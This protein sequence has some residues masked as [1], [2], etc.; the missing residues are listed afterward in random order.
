M[1]GLTL[2][3]PRA[4]QR[5]LLSPGHTL[6]DGRFRVE[7][8]L[9]SGGEGVVYRV[10]D[11]AQ[12]RSIA[13]KT[14]HFDDDASIPNLKREFRFLRDLI[15]PS[16]VQLHELV[17]S[18]EIAFF[19]MA[20]VTGESFLTAAKDEETLREL[21]I[22]LAD[23]TAFLHTTGRVHRDIK[24]SNILV[25]PNGSL[26]LLDFGIGLNLKRPSESGFRAQGTPR[27]M[28]PELLRGGSVSPACDAFS[29]GVLLYEALTGAHPSP[30]GRTDP[31]VTSAPRPSER[32]P[33]VARDLDDLVESLLDPAPATRGT[34]E[35]ILELTPP[36]SGTDFTS[37]RTTISGEIF[38]GRLHELGRLQESFERVQEGYKSIVAF[39]EAESG[40][41]KTAF[42]NRFLESQADALVFRSKCSEHE[43][44]PHKA[45]DG[46]ID[47]LV[48]YLL[49]KRHD[50]VEEL[51]PTDDAGI[52][53]QLFPEFGR[54]PSLESSIP[55]SRSKG[56]YRAL[57][58]RAYLAL[59]GVLGRVSDEASLIIAIDDL[60]WGDTDSGRLLREVFAG[61]DRPRCLLVLAYRSEERR[62]SPCLQGVLDGE[63]SLRAELT[64]TTIRLAPLLR[65][66]AYELISNVAGSNRLAPSA[67][68]SIVQEAKGSPLLLTELVTHIRSNPASAHQASIGIEQIVA[69]RVA[70]LP[71]DHRRAFNL[72]CCS[73]PPLPLGLLGSLCEDDAENVLRSL[74]NVRL[75]RMRRGGQEI[76]VFHDSIR[77]A[78]LRQLGTKQQKVHAQLAEGL[79]VRNGDPAEIA[80]HFEASGQAIEASYW[81]E[82]AAENANLSF[83]LNQAVDLY[84]L[85]LRGAHIAHIHRRY[86]RERLATALA[87][88]GR[89]AEAAPLFSEL[90]E[91]ATPD[92][93]IQLRRRAAEQWLISGEADLGR[94]TL[95]LVQEAVGLAWPKTPGQAVR[96]FLWERLGLNFALQ[97]FKAA[98]AERPSPRL[99]AQLEACRSAWPVAFIS[100]VHGSANSARYLRLAIKRGAPD[101]LAIG[102]GMEAIYRASAGSKERE[103]V[104]SHLRRARNLMPLP[105]EGYRHA[106][107]NYIEAQCSFLLGDTRLCPGPHEE[108]ERSFLDHCRNVSWELNSGRIF[109]SQALSILGR[110][111]EW[112]RR[113]SGWLADAEDRGDAC[114]FGAVKVGQAR[115]SIVTQGDAQLAASYVSEGRLRWR[116][117]FG[118]V[119][120]FMER[121]AYAHIHACTGRPELALEEVDKIAREMRISH[122]NRAQVPRT[123]L[124]FHE[125]FA[126]VEL[127]ADATSQRS[128]QAYLARARRA[129]QRLRKEEARWATAFATQIEAS[130][131]LVESPNEQ[132]LQRL[133]EAAQLFEQLDF[134]LYHAATLARLGELTG[135]EKGAELVD[136]GRSAFLAVH[137]ADWMSTLG[138]F[139]PRVLPR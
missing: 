86:L 130:A 116:T 129:C 60:Q 22:Q 56:E 80:R 108:A 89:G 96:R 120:Y 50:E 34:I 29:I 94:S 3:S 110:F 7:E 61:P 67:A 26:I 126:C 20:L 59:A 91:D 14:L 35:S 57:R 128:Q 8:I 65:R 5:A 74:S 55:N 10:F 127:A 136:E 76:E 70:T 139:A 111:N 58:L 119:H 131:S 98:P 137:A 39:V 41:G 109:W 23:V 90:A 138:G 62:R 101:H 132:G 77:E 72:L 32:R 64:S 54:L 12:S 73:G 21:L 53:L 38:T 124:A 121:F 45:I 106:F 24:D 99:D 103:V 9:G 47:D 37:P 52:L 36:H 44:I 92:E 107:L 16:L 97:G 33:E 68:E 49:G 75:A 115:L 104:E 43:L 19:T 51:I 15:H 25:Q 11:H 4:G 27:Y 123:H 117:P 31:S 1:T 71:K 42:L 17:V 69:H 13:L 81:A 134:R 48:A 88:C 83:A 95:A 125:G 113:L 135:G 118:G 133:E 40:M 87:D 46:V 84:R 6:V 28:A 105:H 79:L 112:D 114:L 93:A 85:A 66:D 30:S 102:F 63:N 2:T 100:T 82:T 18:P 78:M 122:M